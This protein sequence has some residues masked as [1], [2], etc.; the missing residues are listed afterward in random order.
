VPQ[1]TRDQ[2]HLAAMGAIVGGIVL[3]LVISRLFFDS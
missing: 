1:E 2:I 3:F